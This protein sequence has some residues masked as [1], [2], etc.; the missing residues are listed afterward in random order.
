MKHKTGRLSKVT[1]GQIIFLAIIIFF[2]TVSILAM[3][4]YA[5][6]AFGPGLRDATPEEIAHYGMKFHLRDTIPI[7]ELSNVSP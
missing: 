1:K 2:F 4:K 5:Q 6:R 3:Q 7:S